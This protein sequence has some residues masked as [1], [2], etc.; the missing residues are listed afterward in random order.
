MNKFGEHTVEESALQILESLGYAIAR[1]AEIAPG[2]PGAEREGYGQVVLEGRLRNALR[3]LNPGLPEFV[4]DEVMRN[5]LLPEGVGVVASNEIFHRM[6]TDGVTVQVPVVSTTSSMDDRAERTLRWDNARL[7]DFEHPEMNDWLVV[8]QFT[9]TENRRERRPDLVVFI[10]GLPLGVIELKS[11]V[12]TSA[13]LREA[14][15]QLRNYQ[16]EIPGLFI[17]N[18]ALVISDGTYA[19]VGTITAEEERFMPWRTIGGE[20]V[21]PATLPELEVLLNG[22][23][24]Q[25]RF[26]AMIRHFIVFEDDGR[27]AP[28]KKMAGYHQF[29]AVNYGLEQTLRAVNRRISGAVVEP[30]GGYQTGQ[31]PGGAIGD[32]RVGVVWHTQGSGKSLTMAFYAGRVALHPAMANPTIVVLTDRNDLDNQLYGVFARCS[33]LLRQLPVQAESRAHLR[34]LLQVASGGV[35]FTTIQKFLPSIKRSIDAERATAENKY[36]GLPPSNVSAPVGSYSGDLQ[37]SIE[38]VPALLSDRWNIVVI[39][40]EAHRSQYDFIDGFARHMRDALPNAAFIGFTGTPIE[41]TDAN[42]RAVFG[43]YISVYDIE[44][45][46]ADGATVPIYYE[47]RL[48]RIYL[49]DEERPSLD[50]DFEEATEGEELERKERLKTKWAQIEALVA[51][52][53]RLARVAADIVEHFERRQ[54][55]MQGKG[56]IVG[57]SRGICVRLYEAIRA[58]RPQWYD[59]DDARGAM[60]IVMTGS[61]ADP[62]DWQEHVRTKEGRERIATRFRD[63]EDPLMLVFVRDMW[64]TGFDVAPLHTMYIDKPMRGH[65]L[66]QAIARVNRVFRDKPSGLIVDYI[67][68]APQLREALHTYTESGGS[69]TTAHDVKGAIDGMLEEFERCGD[70]LYGLNWKSASM[71]PPTERLRILA[72]AQEHVL[73]QENGRMRFMNAALRLTR[74]YAQ[75]AASDEARAICDDVG[76]LQAVRSALGKGDPWDGPDADRTEHA[77]RDLVSRAVG[78]EGVIDIFAAAGLHKPD[79]SILSDAFLE[80]VRALPHKN[81]AVDVLRKLLAK[82]IRSRERQNVVQ[83]RSFTEMLDAAIRRYRNRAVETAQVIEELIGLAKQI[84]EED[85]RGEESGLSQEERAFYDALGS[86]DSAVKLLGEPVLRLMAQELTEMIRRNATIDW[87]IKESVRARLRVLVKRIL[88]RHGYPPDRQE[89]AT[90]SVLEQA[91][92]SAADWTG[93]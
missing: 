1:G 92:A 10:N 73:G 63:S 64:L 79:I 7:I 16:V 6:L 29:H 23:F 76:F 55:A 41:R 93:V 82:E 77:I 4:V 60:K 71:L 36:L 80:E 11:A 88:R 53:E 12:R 47:S 44:R 83:A 5:V 17:Y 45:A 19:R 87:T 33:G 66:M 67:G 13:G 61:A 54:E 57:M 27:G 46:I 40:D 74:W 72:V 89:R 75:A 84:H 28:N 20:T 52:P 8:S 37:G 43:E 34:S 3:R 15:R 42:T 14:F 50:E 48:A 91:E 49:R 31:R 70:L 69:G 86:N 51:T 68:L 81:L 59:P 32:R 38:G 65:A 58:I 9:V 18:E 21:A 25:T 30:D 85:R 56:M 2:E 78:T 24:E 22:I 26:L 35:I 39:A 90:Q 62:A